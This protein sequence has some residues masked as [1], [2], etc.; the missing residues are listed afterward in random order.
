MIF[1]QES[2]TVGQVLLENVITH[3]RIPSELYTDQG[4]NFEL[5]IGVSK[6]VNLAKN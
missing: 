4:R 1:N 2:S 3:H 5:D 6:N